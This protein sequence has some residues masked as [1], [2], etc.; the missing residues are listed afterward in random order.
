MAEE[1]PRVCGTDAAL[2]DVANLKACAASKT[3]DGTNP[4]ATLTACWVVDPTY[5]TPASLLGAATEHLYQLNHVYAALPTK[6]AN[7]TANT[8]RLYCCFVVWGPH[9][10]Y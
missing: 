6:E 10:E 7:I 3:V 1:A 2:K 4:M 8:N 5:A 9:T